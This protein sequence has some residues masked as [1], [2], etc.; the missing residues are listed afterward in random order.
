[1]VQCSRLAL[2]AGLALCLA[3][4]ATA[5]PK[6]P[7]FGGHDK[8]AAGA[9]LKR[10]EW[11]QARSDVAPDPQIRFGALANGMRYAILRNATPPGSASLRLRFDAGSL[12]EADAQSGLAHFLEH[13]AFDGST[14]AP[15]GEMVK[16]LQRLGLAFGADTNASTGFDATL[17]RFDL[18][19][20][21]DDSLDT[22]L[23]LLRGT[24]DGLTLA[25]D[26]IDKERGVVLS[27][28]RARDTP[29]W[30][31]FKARLGFLLE[32]QR[33]P[34]R[35]PIGD[36]AV[37]QKADRARIA[38]FYHRWYRPERAVLIAVGDFDVAA[39]EAKIQAAFGGWRGT[40]PAGGD[41]DLGPVEKRG[42]AA[43]LAVDPGAPTSIQLSW[44]APPDL[45]LD[46]LARRRRELIEQL[47]LA[48]LNRRLASLARGESAPFL[49]A[50]AFRIDQSHAARVASVLVAAEA[51]H[52]REA[53]GAADQEQ[54]R[55]VAFGVRPEELTR[56][57]AEARAD[58][59]RAA[60]QAATR[61]TPA[62]ADDLAGALDAREVDTSPAQDLALFEEVAR[63]LTPEQ[64]S[65]ALKDA[66]QGAGPLIFM[67]SPSAVEGGE[68]TVQAVYAASRGAGIAPAKAAAAA[69]W[70]Y[71]DFG[72]PGKVVERREV[73]DLDTVFVRFA[74]GVRLTVKPTK[75]RDDE[76]RVKVR[77]G[78][79]LASLPP[80]RQTMSWAGRAL[81]EGGLARISAD[82]TERALASSVYGAEYHLEDDAFALTGAT[83]REDL[84][85]QMQ[86]LAAYASDPGWRPEAFARAQTWAATLLDQYAHTDF[87]V[88]G[89]DLAGLMHAGDRRWT[90]PTREEMSAATLEDLKR[91]AAPLASDPIEVVMVGDIT[92]DKAIA[93]AAATFG[94]LP[95][96]AAPAP[97]PAPSTGFPAPGG[98]PV[99]LTHAG[100]AD[101]AIALAA[102]RTNDFFAD[103]REARAVA[104]LGQVL[105]LR[106][107]DVLRRG[108]GVTYSP[109]VADSESLVWPRWGYVSASVEVPPAKLDG[110][111][112]DI[113]A[114]CADLRSRDVGADELARAKTPRL[115]TV[116]KTRQTNAWWLAAL[117]RVQSDPRRLAVI[118][119]EIASYEAVT[120]ADL[121]RA[122]QRYLRDDAM[123][124]LEVK[125]GPR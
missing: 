22:A 87:G 53:L 64:A 80:G 8:A 107:L 40:G 35:Y 92:V 45:S 108:Q 15:D 125:P 54:R 71:T 75:F 76:V 12:M 33:P 84:D 68:A 82:D 103:P 115:E 50:A 99:A 98:A 70:P 19:K 34:L 28:E 58:L 85:A 89:R 25:P 63:A 5:L 4:A 46:T 11:P 7:L 51:G 88:L 10:G 44:A 24:A 121:R 18:P 41:P 1:M 79:G 38:D 61:R 77:A 114:I 20:A 31:I 112:R 124:K 73:A 48:V 97:H 113:A 32:G 102:W 49:S 3:G 26:A 116:A 86:V 105:Q 65:G 122:A 94:A 66:F 101:Q 110:V 96:R 109:Q 100:R 23:R 59:T 111:F 43:R 39:V 83:R 9:K 29:A 78:G 95:P 90:F 2:G 27:E 123:W 47:A 91:E 16:A 13:L 30:R 52:W 42:L 106:L 37:I 119:S 74:N 118:R 81:I 69:T 55:A 21:D 67:S 60:A 104:V 117:S 57:I 56:E 93:A 6:L 72:E 14:A 120:P 36:V 62:L 17:Y